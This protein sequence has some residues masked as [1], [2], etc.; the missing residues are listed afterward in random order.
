MAA[1]A[2][3]V[4]RGAI[5]NFRHRAVPSGKLSTALARC[6]MLLR[7]IA[8]FLGCFSLLNLVLGWVIAGFD[9]NI[10]WIDFRVLP[11]PLPDLALALAGATLVAYALFGVPRGRWR[12]LLAPG[13]VMVVVFAALNVVQFYVLLG[14][15]AIA[16]A[17]P[18]PLSLLILVPVA[19][20]VGRMWRG[21]SGHERVRSWPRRG[22]AAAIFAATCLAF[23]LAQVLCFGHTDYRRPADAVVVFGARAY[24]S[25]RMST[26][27]SDRIATAVELY[28][29]GLVRVVVVS[30]GPGDGDVHET[31]AMRR[32]AVENGVPAAA[33]VVDRDGLSTQDPVEAALAQHGHGVAHGVLGAQVVAVDHD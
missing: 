31:E 7:P 3:A 17:I 30:G 8:L 24:A 4:G 6:R 23:P 25:G 13:L 1:A 10:W 22:L 20:M 27:L 12:W 19:A 21:P 11:A 2:V 26:A 28:R 14:S 18:V 33:I 5:G 15:G 32:Y 16:T 29:T 9:A